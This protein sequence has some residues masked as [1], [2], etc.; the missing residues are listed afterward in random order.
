MP[1]FD[2]SLMLNCLVL[3]SGGVQCQEIIN[4][5][6]LSLCSAC[7]SLSIDIDLGLGRHFKNKNTFKYRTMQW[8]NSVPVSIKR[9]SLPVVKKKLRTWVKEN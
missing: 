7:L 5:A 4:S 6:Q 2:D 8:Y 1:I 3:T 9:G